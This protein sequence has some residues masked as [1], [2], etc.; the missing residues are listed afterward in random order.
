MR[1]RKTTPNDIPAL[2]ALWQE[3]FEDTQQ[4][5]D[6]FFETLYPNAI[7]FCAEEEGEILSML[8]ALPQ[9]IIKGEKQLK[10]AYLYA[11][12]T[13]KEARGRGYCK[14]VFACAEKE[15]RKRYFEA[16]LLSPASEELAGF[17][18]KL[19]FMRQTGA[20]K[21]RIS[22]EA[23]K[24]QA[25]EV[26]VQD[27]AGL[28]ETL[29]WDIPHVRYDKAQLE[30]ALSGGK[31]Y[32]LMA[33]YTMGCAVVKEGENGAQAFVCEMLPGADALSALAEKRGTGS[34]EV[35][36]ALEDAGETWSML[37]WLTKPDAAFE[38]VYMGFAL[39]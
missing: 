3:A 26:G 13:K 4:D 29:L 28:R 19:G 34:Y 9:T 30:Y 23:V 14:A 38:P 31:Y 39:E 18:A 17:Y 10:A 16:L 8:F 2:T 33:G 12:A 11:V 1:T 7:G 35:L 22:C 15:L 37:K 24:G 20:K 21:A 6:A 27:Y 36:S 25:T 5:I 32:C